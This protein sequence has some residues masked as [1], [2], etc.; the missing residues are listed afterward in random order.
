MLLFLG[1]PA[2]TQYRNHALTDNWDGFR[3][4]HIDGDFLA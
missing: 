4:C 3:A 2:P 1:E